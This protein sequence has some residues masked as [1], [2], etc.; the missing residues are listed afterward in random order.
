MF[1]T[2]V[3]GG[4]GSKIL[5]LNF[6]TSFQFVFYKRQKETT[7]KNLVINQWKLNLLQQNFIDI[8]EQWSTHI[9]LENM[10]YEQRMFFWRSGYQQFEPIVI[11][12]FRAFGK[13]AERSTRSVRWLLYHERI[14][15]SMA[16]DCSTANRR[17]GRKPSMSSLLKN[18][19]RFDLFRVLEH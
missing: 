8:D 19:H 10:L 5:P 3:G 18:A 1:V 6:N 12:S 16:F 14:R 2:S 13:Q 4:S 9:F 11:P 15:I 7:K 17:V